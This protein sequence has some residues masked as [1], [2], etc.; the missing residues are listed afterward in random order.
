ME[1]PDLDAIRRV[2]E[3]GGNVTDY[4]K[5]KLK[6]DKNTLE[7]IEMAYDLQAGSYINDLN[8]NFERVDLFTSEFCDLLSPHLLPQDRLLDIGTGEMT[9]IGLIVNKLRVPIR[10]VLAFDISWSRIDLGVK[11]WEERVNS[12]SGWFHLS[13]TLK[14]SRFL[15]RVWTLLHR[16]VHWNLMAKICLNFC[17]KFLEWSKGYVF[18]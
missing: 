8:T 9:T 5:N 14:V 13:R 7:V 18:F 1:F 11:F 16:V 3:N 4:L 12:Q 17:K 2:Y 6:L 15:Q 10:E